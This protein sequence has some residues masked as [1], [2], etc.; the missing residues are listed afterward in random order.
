MTYFACNS[1]DKENGR[2][3]CL[4]AAIDRAKASF[5]KWFALMLVIQGAAIVALA[6]LP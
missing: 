6:A 1:N 5:I 2:P 3:G 4:S